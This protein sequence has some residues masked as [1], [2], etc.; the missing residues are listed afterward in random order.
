M[1]RSLSYLPVLQKAQASVSGLVAGF[2]LKAMDN[3]IVSV[4]IG[5]LL[6]SD[7]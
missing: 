4:S 6:D 5:A 1:Q 2:T 7:P 3:G